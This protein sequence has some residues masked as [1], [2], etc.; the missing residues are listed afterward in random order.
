MSKECRC[1][2]L[3]YL[4]RRGCHLLGSGG[5]DWVVLA[6][7]PLT[8]CSRGS[9][10]RIFFRCHGVSGSLAVSCA[11]PGRLF[12]RSNVLGPFSGVE[13][14]SFVPL[15]GMEIGAVSFRL[16]LQIPFRETTCESF[17][18]VILREVFRSRFA[19][20]CCRVSFLKYFPSCSPST[21]CSFYLA[22]LRA[23]SPS[24]LRWELA[25]WP[26]GGIVPSTFR[27]CL[28]SR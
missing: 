19:L 15:E 25:L 20:V 13:V 12:R 26:L 5:F 24:R 1:C 14:R 8:G 28:F 9:Y 17:E 21:F 23:Y 10:S 27:S 11:V 7:G 6:C 2:A 4:L 3:L 22:K 16:V 18:G